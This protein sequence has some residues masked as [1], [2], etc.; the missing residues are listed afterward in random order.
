MKHMIDDQAMS[1]VAPKIGVKM[2]PAEAKAYIDEINKKVLQ[3]WQE[4]VTQGPFMSKFL[5]GALPMT[6]PHHER[7]VP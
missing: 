3:R 7:L 6:A 5:D 4:R 1:T 2:S